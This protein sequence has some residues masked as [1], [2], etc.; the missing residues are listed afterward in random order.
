MLI[1]KNISKNFKK[2]N[3]EINVLKNITYT[4]KE[5]K[6]YAIKGHSGSGKSTLIKIMG[7]IEQCSSGEYYINNK[8]VSEMNDKELSNLRMKY[9]GFIFQD[10]NLDP[11]LSAIDNVILPMLINHNINREDRKKKANSLLESLGL[12][13]RIDHYPKE[14]S[15][16]ELGRV[17]IARALA[18]DP[19]IILA[20][21]PTGNLDKKN[22]KVVLQELKKLA[23]KGK[24]VIVVSHSDEINQY[25]DIILEL[26]DGNI[27]TYKGK[28][29]DYDEQ[30]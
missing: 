22:E 2:G 29:K 15:G 4:F 20:D 28:K 19:K 18:N 24:C 12:K 11:Y 9:I 7:L 26:D 23:D 8:N 21:E 5:G 1:L 30:K 27:T 13:D 6:I 25:A 14:L 16:G 17:A 10:F 3:K